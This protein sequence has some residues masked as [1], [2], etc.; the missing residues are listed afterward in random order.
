MKNEII[1]Y[2][3]LEAASIQTVT[4]WVD[5]DGRFWG[6]NEYQARWCGCTH[7]IC[8]KHPEEPPFIKNYGCPKCCT[9]NHNA[10]FEK[11]PK[12]EWDG[13]TP[14]VL[15]NDDKYFFDA[16]SLRDYCEEN[17]VDVSELQLV[18]CT[19]NYPRQQDPNDIFCDDLPE[20][21]EVSEELYLAFEALNK[22]IANHPPL[23][24]SPGDKS[25]TVNLI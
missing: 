4:G 6:D 23:S 15:F 1:L 21:G 9:E 25:V 3:S 7:I 16:D 24:W 20:D 11:M 18:I 10:T 5:R 14:L 13:E 22:V 8:E 12:I 19:P 17:N 2:A